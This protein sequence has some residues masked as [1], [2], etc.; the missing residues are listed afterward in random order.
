MKNLKF[1]FD[2]ILQNP[3]DIDGALSSSF[4]LRKKDQGGNSAFSY[5][6][7]L[8]LSGAAATYVRTKI[9]NAAIPT[10]EQIS[11]KIYSDCCADA[12]G[13]ELL[14]FNGKIEGS[15]VSYCEYP[16]DEIT[17]SL[18]DDSDDGKAI[19]CLKSILIWDK[20]PKFDG[21]GTS[22][23]ENAYR[24][25]RFTS[26]CID[27]R[28]GFLQEIILI[29]G[30]LFIVILTPIIF[31]VA[32]LVT[33]IN[34]II[35]VVNAFGGNIDLI[36]GDINF[37]DDALVFINLL[38]ELVVGCGFKH[39]TPFVHSY[40]RNMCDLCGLNL[41][42]SLF[43]PGGYY[44][45]TMQLDAPYVPGRKVTTK[46]LRNW[47]KN[48]PN[49][50]GLQYLEAMKDWNIAWSI[51][52]GVLH[53]EREDY[54]FGTLWFD[55]RNIAKE[56][57]GTLCFSY[58]T[59]KPP[60]YGEYLYS[61]DGVDNTG[62][63]VVDGWTD[64]VFDWNIPVN[65]AQSGLKQTTLFYSAGQF[66]E[67]S[68]RDDVSA[69]DKPIYNVAFPILADYEGALLME[70]GVCGFPKWLV[71]DGV[72]PQDDARILR[73]PTASTTEP[74]TFD[75]N[76][77]WWIKSTYRDGNNIQRDT[78]YQALFEIDD[79]RITGIKQ[80]NYTLSL[81]ADCDILKGMSADRFI[82]IPVNGVYKNATIEEIEYNSN[83]YLITIT[84]KV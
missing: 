59:E 9:I 10:L 41:Q 48:K 8:S 31:I 43:N 7:D 24:T 46:I 45:N 78:A 72:S 51:S 42:S 22:L 3:D 29:F 11:V 13:N 64:I 15:E 81:Y 60:A 56:D 84:G 28:P 1:Y 58:S 34:V 61:K 35:T 55:L 71:W 83:T 82:I 25:S 79:P 68:N 67:D 4:T 32:T 37:Y 75:Y 27:L 77:N 63:E 73:Y 14:L 6:P 74:G 69:L 26:Y 33:V 49:T 21:S 40:L 17:V 53:V 76:V 54:E 65:P 19:A 36:G 5:S 44:H 62:D 52:G 66:R 16:C 23:G 12:N 38:Q 47:E 80:L 2:G 30:F 70:K 50:N 20:K 57:I 18:V 39:K